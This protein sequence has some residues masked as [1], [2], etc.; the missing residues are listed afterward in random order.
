MKQIVHKTSMSI[1]E[2]DRGAL[3]ATLNSTLASSSDLYAQLKQAHWNVKGPEFIALHKLFDELAEHVQEQVD[4]IAERIT[5]LGGT[6]LGTLDQA[7]KNSELKKYPIDIFSAKEHLT[8]LAHNMALLGKSCRSK[9]KETE[10]TDMA[11][12]DLYIEITRQLD[13]DLWFI[14]AHLQK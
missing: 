12:S 3:I 14:E 2:K 5:A 13:K 7:V 8:H 11:T 9:I 10:K 6:A 4:T 1:P